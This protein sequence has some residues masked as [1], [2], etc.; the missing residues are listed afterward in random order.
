MNIPFKRTR[1]A[2]AWLASLTLLAACGG[3]G[4]D[5]A[6]SNQVFSPAAGWRN[7]H[8]SSHTWTMTGNY[9]VTG[10]GGGSG[11]ASAVRTETVSPDGVFPY[12]GLPAKRRLLDLSV[13]FAGSS[14]SSSM[15]DYLDVPTLLRVGRT[16]DGGCEAATSLTALPEQA[17]LGQSGTWATW[18]LLDSCAAGATVLGS[19]NSTWSVEAIGS[20][21]YLCET[22]TS[23][24]LDGTTD[25][26]KFCAEQ[27]DSVG[28]PGSSARHTLASSDSTG[29]VTLQLATSP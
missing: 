17:T 2:G 5:M 25:V 7:L 29:S 19:G 13:S 11:P 6:G 20:R 28:T 8:A 18:T 1:L 24:Y 10:S 27:L 23:H 14:F 4:D 3:G 26:D 15:L 21:A 9:V 12:D 16:Y 22:Q